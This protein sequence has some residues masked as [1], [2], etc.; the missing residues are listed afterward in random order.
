MQVEQRNRD[1]D[2]LRR[3]KADEIETI[4]EELNDTKEKYNEVLE[5]SAVTEGPI[6]H[7]IGNMDPDLTRRI[8][9]VVRKRE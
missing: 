1:V 8:S 4:T 6:V 3:Q 5:T 7:C 9:M 2:D